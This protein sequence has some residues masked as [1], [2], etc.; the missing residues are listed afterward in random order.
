M[1][2]R[3]EELLHHLGQDELTPDQTKILLY[4]AMPKIVSSLL[5]LRL[6]SA[7]LSERLNDFFKLV[8]R[9]T[10]EM[11]RHSATWE[12]IECATRIPV[13]YTH[14]TLPTICSV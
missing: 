7:Q 5:K 10:V 4:N 2:L 13:S 3:L 8:L 1:L 11:L 14:L 9:T 12:L 6:P